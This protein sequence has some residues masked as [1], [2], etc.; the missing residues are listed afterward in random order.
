MLFK[1]RHPE[2]WS[3]W[4]RTLVWPRHS[5]MRSGQYVMK[6]AL[7]ITATPYAVAM[8]LA[9]GAFTSFT[10]FMGLHFLL[11]ATLAWLLRG[12]LLASAL[13][14][15]VGNPVTFPL[16]WATTLATG[17]SFLGLDT[18]S[19]PIH[20]GQA[21]SDVMAALWSFDTEQ[22]ARG[23]AAI[24]EP[25]FFPML[26]GGLPWGLL[27]S[28]IIYFTAYRAALSFREA[29]RT[30]LM[31]KATRIR[32]E[33]RRRSGEAARKIAPPPATT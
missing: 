24:W 7:R 2:G 9:A 32:D 13:G 6:R 14:T 11:A 22:A 27:C 19:A 8:G 25:V 1:R 16:I 33:A 10:P 31:A 18:E 5:W 26:V 30:K 15:F 23:L 28:T 4:L 20:L 29:R 21:M 12:N 3:E 17:R